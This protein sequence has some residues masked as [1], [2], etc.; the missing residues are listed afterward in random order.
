MN[1][2]SRIN[3]PSEFGSKFIKMSPET[4]SVFGLL[5]SGQW[6]GAELRGCQVLGKKKIWGTSWTRVGGSFLET[7]ILETGYPSS[8]LDFILGFRQSS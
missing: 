7:S 5:H 8:V 6:Q 1:I 4:N 2:F 3:K